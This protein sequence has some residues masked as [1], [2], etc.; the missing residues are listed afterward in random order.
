M[1]QTTNYGLNKP[2]GTDVVNISDLNANMD[3]IDE[4]MADKINSTGDGSNLTETFSQA[5]SLGNILTGEKHSAIFGKIAK[6]ISDYISHKSTSAST[7]VSGHV[8]YGMVAGTACQGNDSRLSDDRLPKAHASSTSVYGAG[9]ATNYGHVRLADTY[10][11]SAASS[12]VAVTPK[13][14][15]DVYIGLASDIDNLQGTKADMT[16]SSPTNIHG[17]GS[18]KNF[19]HVKL[20]DEY[21]SNVGAAADGVAA[22]QKAVADAYNAVNSNLQ[23][24]NVAISTANANYITVASNRVRKQGKQIHGFVYFQTIQAV[25]GPA[26]I[27]S[28]GFDVPS[29][30][31]L[32]IFNLTDGTVGYGTL[33][34]TKYCK[35]GS[36]LA[37][38]K[39]YLICIDFIQP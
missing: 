14:L 10:G 36:A 17:A 25:T 13:A 23:V 16:H 30:I 12:G 19:G 5:S 9:N 3:I 1:K 11:S 6:A 38:N 7:T 31:Y 15:S 39:V 26:N 4:K 21:A 35:N 8:K 2:E 37:A 20:S 34:T 29:T 22:S 27:I 18:E 28:V 24:E 32:P 33:E